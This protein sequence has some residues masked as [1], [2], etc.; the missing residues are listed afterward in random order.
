VFGGP[1]SYDEGARGE[2]T[3]ADKRYL[4]QAVARFGA[5]VAGRNT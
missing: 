1:W 4:D 5:V 2:A 3:G